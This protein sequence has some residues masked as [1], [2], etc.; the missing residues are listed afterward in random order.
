L[1]ANSLLFMQLLSATP[2]QLRRKYVEGH[3]E[4]PRQSLRDLAV[5]L[6]FGFVRNA[7]PNN[8]RTASPILGLRVLDTSG[9]SLYLSA[10]EVGFFALPEDHDFWS[11]IEWDNFRR[12]N[13]AGKEYILTPRHTGC[14]LSDPE[15]AVLNFEYLEQINRDL[16]LRLEQGS[17]PTWWRPRRWNKRV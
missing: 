16:I 6:S 12:Y 13:P 17:R 7:P 4:E 14:P 1:I 2:A 10:E 8:Y 9:S 11:F 5:C 3:P 15:V